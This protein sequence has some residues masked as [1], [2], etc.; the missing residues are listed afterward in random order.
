MAV[1]PLQDGTNNYSTFKGESTFKI[2]NFEHVLTVA[3]R[4]MRLW[5]LER[6]RV[7]KRN[8]LVS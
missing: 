6:R 7:I 3:F 5:S 4:W 1:I 8:L 2:K